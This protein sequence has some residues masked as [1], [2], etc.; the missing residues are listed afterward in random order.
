[1]PRTHQHAV[2]YGWCSE[3]LRDGVAVGK[4]DDWLFKIGD[5][6]RGHPLR[7]IGLTIQ[8]LEDWGICKAGAN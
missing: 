5:K 1:M 2:G 4:F 7:F 8:G 6:L 3:Y